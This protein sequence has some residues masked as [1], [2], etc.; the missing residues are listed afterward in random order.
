MIKR[1]A[2]FVL[3]FSLIFSIASTSFAASIVS[4][5]A[6]CTKVST[7][8]TL[9]IKGV[10]KSYVCTSNPS[11][12]IAAPTTWT[13]KNCVSFW[14]AAQGQQD[15][16]NQQLTLVNVM[17]DPDKTM[18]TNKLKKSQADLDKVFSAI[19]MN[20]CKSGL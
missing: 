5:G 8:V 2:V 16:I 17:T 11:S 13:L 10:S 4:N 15:N 1:L 18:Y 6:P 9:K 12:G 20:W 7:S 3:G 14:K 19:K